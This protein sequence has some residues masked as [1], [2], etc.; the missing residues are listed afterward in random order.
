LSKR[1]RRKG[2]SVNAE[3]R[4]VVTD[5]RRVTVAYHKGSATFPFKTL[6]SMIEDHARWRE[7][8]LKRLGLMK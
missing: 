6:K 8:D 5:A 2:L 1:W 3:G 7:E 4:G